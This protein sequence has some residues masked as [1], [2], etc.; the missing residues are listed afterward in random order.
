MINQDALDAIK[1]LERQAA[2]PV[3]QLFIHGTLDGDNARTTGMEIW[4]V[5]N[6]EDLLAA[7]TAK[8]QELIDS[9]VES[10]TSF[11]EPIFSPTGGLYE[12]YGIPRGKMIRNYTDWYYTVHLKDGSVEQFV[13]NAITPDDA[14]FVIDTANTDQPDR[15]ARWEGNISEVFA[16]NPS[17]PDLGTIEVDPGILTLGMIMGLSTFK[18]YLILRML[19][20]TNQLHTLK[21]KTIRILRL[22]STK[23]LKTL[24]KMSLKTRLLQL[25]LAYHYKTLLSLSRQSSLLLMRTQG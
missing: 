19:P 16:S 14:V 1:E 13:V 24:H 10:E 15:V 17:Y 22:L 2:L 3:N 20:I 18:R 23:T 6:T 7:I 5:D 25:T 8:R 12:E 4:G 9:G 11:A 21:Q